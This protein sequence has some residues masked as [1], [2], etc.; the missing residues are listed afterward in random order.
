MLAVC[1]TPPMS[2][3]TNR[4]IVDLSTIGVYGNYDGAWVD[5][6]AECRPSE[7]R[8]RHRLAAERGWQSLSTG[9][10]IPVAI[11]RLAG[12]YG[13]GRNALKTSDT[14]RPNTSSSR[15]R[16][17]IGSMWP[18]SRRQSMTPLIGAPTGSSI[19]PM[20]SRASQAIRSSMPQDFSISSRRQTFF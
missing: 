14:A 11:L 10:G 8:N 4:T 16:F 17:S 3:R 2:S 18:I 1:G 6:N 7:E 13:P 5:E 12:I 19:L 15:A 9:S 20:T